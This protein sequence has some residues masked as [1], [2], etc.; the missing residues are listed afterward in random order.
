[1]LKLNKKRS[2]S[3]K[4]VEIKFNRYLESE[5]V[6]EIC[7]VCSIRFGSY[8]SNVRLIGVLNIYVYREPYIFI[9]DKLQYFILSEMFYK[10]MIMVV[11][12]NMCIKVICKWYMDS[13]VYKQKSGYIWRL[14]SSWVAD[15]NISFCIAVE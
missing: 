9:V 7:K 8:T 10:N 15:W 1:M 13:I 12:K 2:F 4:S 11:L 14:V 3:I 6:W 5:V